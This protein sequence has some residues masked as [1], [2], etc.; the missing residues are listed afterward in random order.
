MRHC[1]RTDVPGLQSFVGT[2]IFAI[3]LKTIDS[4]W[5]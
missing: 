3:Q 5:P 4:S 1:T 2:I